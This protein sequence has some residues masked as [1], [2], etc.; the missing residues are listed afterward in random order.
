MCGI[1]GVILSRGLVDTE[2]VARMRDVLMHRG[3]DDKGIY[4]K[5]NVGFGF[6]RLSIIDLSPD[7]AQPMANEDGTIWLVYNGE[8]YNYSELR[9]ELCRRGHVF[10]S[11]TDSEVVIHAF[12]EWGEHC[13]RRFNGMFA[14][15]LW[16][17]KNQQLFAARDRL[18]VKPFFYYHDSDKLIFGSELKAILQY[19]SIDT[20]ADEAALSDYF[21]LNYIPPPRTPFRKIRALTPGHY[22]SWQAGELKDT[23]YWDVQVTAGNGHYRSVRD[24][25]EEL[26]AR[27]AEAVRRRLVA[28]VPLGAFLSGGLDSSAVVYF[29]RRFI[30]Q[31]LKTFSVRFED[32]SYDE[33]P[34][35]CEI[36]QQLQTDHHEIVC[37]SQQL[38]STFENSVRHADNLTA[39][40]SNVPLYLVSR[41]AKEHVK[42]V[43]SGDGGDEVFL[44]YPIYQADRWA[45]HYRRLP[46]WLHRFVFSPIVQA[47]PVSAAKLSFDYKARKFVEGARR[48][49][50]QAHFSWRTI[51]NDAEKRALFTPDFAATVSDHCPAQ[52]WEELF[53]TC[54]DGTY[55][56]NGVYSDYKTFLAGSIL[57]KVDT[58]SMANSLEARTPFLDYEF[59][60]FMARVPTAMK[61]RGF[62]TKYLF[63]QA[64]RPLLPAR[65][66]NRKKAGFHTPL[67]GWFR[68]E[69][70]PWVDEILSRERISAT[71]RLDPDMVEQFKTEHFDGRA[72]H[73]L[74]LWGLMNFVAWNEFYGRFLG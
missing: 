50:A 46:V 53:S 8:I 18:G 19:P 7:G 11:H 33:G 44:G 24:V 4:V 40:L 30:Q 29:M 48:P 41:L 64:M 73:A 43:L 20:S 70:R 54:E 9:D 28:D 26:R 69:L 12:E 67:P 27:L 58:M 60:E 62:K 56:E 14:F 31:P 37:T 74:K 6:R 66:V 25:V 10:R 55:F 63:K 51:F 23:K 34:Y 49:P 52:L 15:A 57:P 45:E 39:D 22:L 3:P 32:P 36:A 59:V 21:S 1:S 71:K 47:L 16:D 65:I 38:I 2:S 61:M 5:D 42:V 35:A 17:E 13:L 72:N 68:G